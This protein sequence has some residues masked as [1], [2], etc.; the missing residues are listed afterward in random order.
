MS[1][2][3]VQ[4]HALSRALVLPSRAKALC[5]ELRNAL[6]AASDTG[7]LRTSPHEVFQRVQILDEPPPTVAEQL[8]ALGLFRHAYCIV[9]GDKNQDRDRGIAHLVRDDDAWFD[10]SITVREQ[11]GE[12]ALLAYNFEIRFPPAMGAPFLR[13][14]LNLPEHRNEL[15]ELRSHLHA[16][17]D[18]V[19]IPAPMMAPGEL[20]ALFVHGLRRSAERPEWR[21]PTAFEL[22]WLRTTHDALAAG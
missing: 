2:D 1:L 22:H 15:R 19:Q 12:L 20:I 4:G 21:T 14:D 6:R 13:F 7:Q 3:A 5:R 18:D 11:G 9:G 10:F 8:Q 16:G 17:S